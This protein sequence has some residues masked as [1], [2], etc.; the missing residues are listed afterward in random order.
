MNHH[1]VDGLDPE[2]SSDSVDSNESS[3]CSNNKKMLL[4][5]FY[6][7]DK[8]LKVKLWQN[9]NKKTLIMTK[10]KMWQNSKTQIVTRFKI[11]NFD[12]IQKLKILP[13]SKTQIV[14]ILKKKITKLKNSKCDKIQL[15]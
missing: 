3:E 12:K 10:L 11:L 5:F 8:T 13:N 7:C 14:E 1:F 4:L 2:F 9:L 15:L 6:N